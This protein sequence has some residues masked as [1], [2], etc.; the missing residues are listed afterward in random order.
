MMRPAPKPL[1]RC[2]TMNTSSILIMIIALVGFFLLAAILLVPVY[3]FLK[4]EK[5]ASEQWTPEAV[6]RRIRETS[7]SPNGAS[8]HD[9]PG[10]KKNGV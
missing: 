2:T 8:Q 6:A 3:L 4:R 7:P 10:E 5:K 9:P 1:L